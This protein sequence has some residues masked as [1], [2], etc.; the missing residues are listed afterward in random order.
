MP[1]DRRLV[2]FAPGG[3]ADE[4][5][6]IERVKWRTI[7]SCSKGTTERQRMI[8]SCALDWLVGWLTEAALLCDQQCAPHC[9][10]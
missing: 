10:C 8:M 2:G 3:R 4:R 7:E 6:E 9:Q 1:V 5:T